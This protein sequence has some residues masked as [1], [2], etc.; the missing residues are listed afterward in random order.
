MP[1]L[2]TYTNYGRPINEIKGKIKG[3]NYQNLIDLNDLRAT[4]KRLQRATWTKSR[5]ALV[6]S[7][8]FQRGEKMAAMTPDWFSTASSVILARLPV[9]FSC[10]SLHLGEKWWQHHILIKVF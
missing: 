6:Y 10:L 4:G 7:G 3:A 2:H 5:S 9:I 8:T 1:S